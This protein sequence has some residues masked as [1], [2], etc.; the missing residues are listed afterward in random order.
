MRRLR[1]FVLTELLTAMLMQGLF[2]V[3]LCTSFYLLTSFYSNTQQVLTAREHAERVIAFFDDKIRHAGLG[4]WQCENSA[5]IRARMK[6]V[7][8]NGGILN[9]K[10]LPLHL[11]NR[12][13][14]TDYGDEVILLYAQ[15]DI[16]S[17][18]EEAILFTNSSNERQELNLQSTADNIRTYGV[19]LNNLDITQENWQKVANSDFKVSINNPNNN[20]INCYAV[21]EGVGFPFYIQPARESNI[22]NI[23]IE[24]NNA[25]AIPI[26]SIPPATELM[27]LKCIHMLVHDT[28]EGR[29]LAFENLT[30]DSSGPKW[31]DTYNQEKGIL[32]IYME[33]DRK[34]KIFTLYVLATGGYDYTI[35]TERPKESDWPNRARPL[36]KNNNNQTRAQAEKAWKDTGYD[37]HIIYVSRASWKLNN[38]PENFT[39]D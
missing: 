30:R 31:G 5:E 1:A 18:A 12:I 8:T 29:S 20:D 36:L 22:V 17:K 24:D 34:T 7:V 25:Y 38:I 19:T 2:I 16:S 37:H 27:S 9:G 11:N 23:F 28:S 6:K 14:D 21:A 4:L 33:L 15:R 26:N 3:V 32:E 13:N 35:N 39:W 10:H